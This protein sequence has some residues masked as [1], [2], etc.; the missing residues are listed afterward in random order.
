[1]IIHFINLFIKQTRCIFELYLIFSYLLNHNLSLAVIWR[2]ESLR[3]GVAATNNRHILWF[4]VPLLKGW[5]TVG[6]PQKVEIDLADVSNVLFDSERRR[7]VLRYVVMLLK[8]EW[9]E[10]LYFIGICERDLVRGDLLNLCKIEYLRRR[11]GISRFPAKL[12]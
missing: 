11:Q 4:Q 10:M 1:M 9:I 8:I 5:L 3:F 12:T 7:E 2:H 6:I